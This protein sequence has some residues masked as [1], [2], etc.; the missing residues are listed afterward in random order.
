MQQSIDGPKPSVDWDDF[1]NYDRGSFGKLSM[2]FKYKTGTI[3]LSVMEA[4]RVLIQL[5][6]SESPDFLEFKALPPG[7]E[8]LKAGWL[9]LRKHGCYVV[10]AGWLSG[11]YEPITALNTDAA[12]YE[13]YLET[14]P[15][16]KWSV[17]I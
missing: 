16:H 4:R 7:P 10:R 11:M 2:C 17:S 5:I 8:K 12:T 9:L 6:G 14:K 15:T 3:V 13:K 1:L